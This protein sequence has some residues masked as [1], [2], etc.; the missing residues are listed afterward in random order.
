[1]SQNNLFTTGLI[2]DSYHHLAVESDNNE[3]IVVSSPAYPNKYVL[4]DVA[5]FFVTYLIFTLLSVL[6]FSL[7]FGITN[8]SF[9][10]ASKLQFY[11]KLAIFLPTL[12]ISLVTIG[13]LNNLYTEEHNSHY[14]ESAT[15]ISDNLSTSH[16][17]QPDTRMDREEF[18]NEEYQLS[19][20]TNTDTN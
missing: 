15:N 16:K 1:Y 3:I 14:P 18:A 4:A 6:F 17:T 13:F 9:N 19:A 10:Y 11:Q 20:S 7:F 5:L 12:I 8:F 2:L